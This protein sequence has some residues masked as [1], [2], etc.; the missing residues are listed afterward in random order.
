ME[1]LGKQ[2]MAISARIRSRYAG[3]RSTTLLY[4]ASAEERQLQ[5]FT[6]A[7]DHYHVHK[8]MPLVP[9]MPYKTVF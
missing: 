4:V 2:D 7:E 6:D 5:N 1:I 8:G 9:K 3:G